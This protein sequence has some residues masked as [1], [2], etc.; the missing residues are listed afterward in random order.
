MGRRMGEEM[1][2]ARPTR[3]SARVRTGASLLGFA[4]PPVVLRLKLLEG[5]YHWSLY[6]QPQTSVRTAVLVEW[7]EPWSPLRIEFG[8][9]KVLRADFDPLPHAWAERFR[10]LDLQMLVLYP[11]GAA[12]VSV[13]GTHTAL[14][15]FGRA[16]S[17]KAP[18]DLNRVG[19]S[20][21]DL[22]LLTRAQDEA[23]RAAVD[24]GYYSIPRPLNLQQLAARLRI[25]AASLSERLRR[26]EGRVI[27]RYAKEGAT[28]PWDART[29]FDS[30]PLDDPAGDDEVEL[31]RVTT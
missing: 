2:S 31:F 4:A 16:L 25:S 28:T 5:P 11:N 30:H 19:D 27:L 18:I 17:G 13:A 12:I 24:A 15:T 8:S 22:P 7:L 3:A 1:P 14:A 26:A 10:S 6:V 21:R 23:L 29:I 20:P 9:R